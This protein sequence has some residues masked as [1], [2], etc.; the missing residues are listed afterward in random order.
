MVYRV[1]QF[2]TGK[3]GT[4]A[5]AGI[6]G[7]P[8]LDLVGTWVHSEDKDG[9][10]VGELCGL[11]PLGVRATRDKDELLEL[12]ADC[13]SYMVARTWADNPDDS[14]AELARI[15]R[16]GKNVV[17]A[18]WPALIYPQGLDS[19]VYAELQQA[20]LDGESSLYTSGIDPGFGSTALAI[21]ALGVTSEVRCV[22]SYEIANYTGWKN[23]AM[24]TLMGFGQPDLEQC[25]ILRPGVTAGIFAST[26]RLWADAMGIVLDDVVEENEALYADQPFDTRSI[27][28][29]AGSIC[30]MRFAVKGLV[31][32]QARVVVEHITKLREQDFP[33]PYLPRGGYRVEIEGEPCMRLDL[34]MSSHKGNG[35][36]AAFVACAMSLVNAIPQ[37]CDAPPGVL[38]YLDLL[39]HPSKNVPH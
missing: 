16:S 33:D 19:G 7:H 13:V 18:A 35:L 30:G 4:Q 15:L 31:D 5:V 38:S 10:D 22:H 21:T 8:E 11:E 28:I 3:L 37:V 32:G 24:V 20:C 6:V 1:I 14:I 17:N 2:A 34:E 39:P 23:R 25:P 29:P 26:L 12:P 9:R 36:H 27:H